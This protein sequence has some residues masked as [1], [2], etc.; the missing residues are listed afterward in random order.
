MAQKSACRDLTCNDHFGGVK[1][2]RQSGSITRSPAQKPAHKG[3][4]PKWPK[5]SHLGSRALMLWFLTAPVRAH[6]AI[7]YGMMFFSGK[8]QP[9]WA[10]DSLWQFCCCHYFFCFQ[11]LRWLATVAIR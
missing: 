3:L 2:V 8:E 5:P 4:E 11:G 9:V 1:I 6:Y 10:N 7:V